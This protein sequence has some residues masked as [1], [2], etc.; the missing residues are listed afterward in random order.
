MYPIPKVL[1]VVVSFLSFPKSEQ[2]LQKAGFV[3]QGRC[4]SSELWD[5]SSQTIPKQR[6]EDL[7]HHSNK[8]W[9]DF[10]PPSISQLKRQGGER[11]S[12]HPEYFPSNWQV[13]L[14]CV[15]C[16]LGTSMLLVMERRP[17]ALR[18]LHLQ[19]SYADTPR[20]AGSL[21]PIPHLG[22]PGNQETKENVTNWQR[23]K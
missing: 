1:I 23:Q 19:A 18:H 22:R 14:M 16:S 12:D 20:R 3:N 4:S 13:Q 17:G 7:G 21:L 10:I 5:R 2:L 6:H 15:C 9:T 8:K 11:S